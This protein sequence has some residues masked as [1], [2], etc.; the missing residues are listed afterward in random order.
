MF[1][2]KK[3]EEVAAELVELLRPHF[4]RIMVAGS[5]RRRKP[6][7]ND[8]DLVAIPG[9]MHPRAVLTTL[10][11]EIIRSG[12]KLAAF[13]FKGINV[14]IYYATPQTWGT[15]LLIRT[16]SK[17]SN[18]R[19][20]TLAQNKGWKLKANGDGL[21]NSGGTRIAGDTEESI[22]RALGLP[23]EPPEARG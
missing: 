22:F 18:I 7:V 15:L 9:I 16:G 8:I 12:P 21:F 20:C 4:E 6:Y 13:K 14:D 5:I 23:Y 10:P 11:V 19:L 2:L 3:A 1:L 17:E